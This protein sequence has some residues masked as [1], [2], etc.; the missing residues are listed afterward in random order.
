[1]DT[2]ARLAHTG[3]TTRAWSVAR[4]LTTDAR[5]SQALVRVALAAV[6]WPHGAQHLLGWFGGYGFAGTLTWMTDTLGFPVPIAAAGI[7][8]EFVG[9]IALALGLAARAV[10]LGLAIFMSV[11]ASTHLTSGFFMNWFGRLPAGT[12]GFEYHVL[13]VVLALT[14]AAQGAGAVSVDWWLT[15]RRRRESDHA[16]A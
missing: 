3:T 9:P 6:L 8:F 14:I 15:H 5:W 11:A 4:V 7:V 13:A 1:M 12:E 2:I 10:G 16:G